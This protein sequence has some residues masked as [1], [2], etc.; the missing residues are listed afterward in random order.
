MSVITTIKVY[1]KTKVNLERFKEHRKESYDEI[2]KKL[3]Y[4]ITLFKEN[5]ELGKKLVEEIELTKNRLEQ[6]KLYE[7]LEPKITVKH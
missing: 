7:K 6:R 4:I 5:P 1:Q 3:L 2:L